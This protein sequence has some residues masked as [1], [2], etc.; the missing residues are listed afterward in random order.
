MKNIRDDF[1]LA[2]KITYLDNAALVLKPNVAI[3]ASSD[4]Y[5]KYSISN[6]TAD[7]P[8]GIKINQ[9]IDSVRN[10]IAELTDASSDEVIFTSGTTDSLNKAALMLKELLKPGDEILLSPYNHSSNF[11]PWVEIAKLT[12]SKIVVSDNLL[13]AINNKTK[14]IAYAQVNN[15][16][17]EN[18]EPSEIYKK[19]KKYNALIINDAAQAI[20]WE[21]VSLKNSDMIAFSTNKLYGP[22]G[23]GTLIVKKELLA[24]LKPATYGGGAIANIDSNSN[25]IMQCGIKSFEPGTLNLAGIYMFNES[26]KYMKENLPYKFVQE[27]INLLSEYA[28]KRL[29]EVKGIQIHSKKGNH[30]I[31]FNV[32][33]YNAQD[34]AH[35]LGI[36]NVYVRSGI[37]CAQYLKNIKKES[38]YVRISLAVYNNK[39][40]IDKLVDLLKKGGDYIVL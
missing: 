37:F 11:A 39:N 13:E 21:K 23:L 18:Y 28:Y 26:L 29:S 24:K 25:V 9:T 22:T 38:S 1:E 5:T 30:I 16:F 10:L 14:I 33:N 8:L 32:S 3:K 36:N 20:S 15:S 27:Q 40:D 31:L 2:N 6:R 12:N 35:Y 4:F 34:V 17:F 19:A 7:T